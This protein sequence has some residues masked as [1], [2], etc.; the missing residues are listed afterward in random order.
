M[1]VPENPQS[2]QS[3]QH[4]SSSVEDP[5][6]KSAA[7]SPARAGTAEEKTIPLPETS[8]KD[9]TQKAAAGELT[10]LLLRWDVF[11][12]GLVMMLL[13][14][15][16]L[17]PVR[18]S[19][20][21][22][23]LATGR[24]LWQGAYQFGND[25]FIY[26]DAGHYTV[27]HSWLYDLLLYLG[28]SSFG[29]IALPALKVLLV[30]LLVAVLLQSIQRKNRL[31]LAALCPA[32]AALVFLS[33]FYD[34]REGFV[35]LL[36]LLTGFFIGRFAATSGEVTTANSLPLLQA[37]LFGLFLFVVTKPANWTGF[38]GRA[39]AIGAAVLA[40]ADAGWLYRDMGTSGLLLAGKILVLVVLVQIWL[41]QLLEENTLWWPAVAT[42]LATL[43]LLPFLALRPILV[44]YLFL[45]LTFWFLERGTQTLQEEETFSG[46]RSILVRV[47][48]AYWPILLVFVL[49]VNMDSWFLLGPLTVALYGAGQLLAGL[50]QKKGVQQALPVGIVLLLGLAIC[51]L[52]PQ[53]VRVFA[54]PV[55]LTLPY[56]SEGVQN[57]RVF[58]WMM[59][60][61]WQEAYLWSPTGPRLMALA[62]WLL[63]ALGGISFVV[64]VSQ[65]S[66]SRLLVWAAFLL[67]SLHQV[68]LLGFFV[69]V[70]APILSLN[71]IDYSRRRLGSADDLKGTARS[72][73][74]VV[75]P[76]AV[77]AAFVL[78]AVA[79][80]GLLRGRV[81][82]PPYLAMQSDP[83][84][85]EAAKQI[86]TWRKESKW[87]EHA[88]GL[89]ASPE[90]ANY[91]AWFNPQE[92][93]FVNAR[94]HVDAQTA[95]DFMTARRVL[96]GPLPSSGMIDDEFMEPLRQVMRKWKLDYVI[97]HAPTASFLST[98]YFRLSAWPNE[99]HL[100]F[101]QGRT[102]IFGWRDPEQK[103]SGQRF[104][105]LEI[106]MKK[107]AWISSQAVADMKQWRI[108]KWYAAI[109]NNTPP[110][111]PKRDEAVIYLLEFDRLGPV[112]FRSN[113][114]F[115]DYCEAAG[116]VG[117]L[118]T[119]GNWISTAVLTHEMYSFHQG[120]PEFL[121]ERDDGPTELLYLAIRASRQA[122][123]DDPGDAQ[124]YFVLG[125]A[126]S[127]LATNTS[128]RAWAR[129]FPKIG[130]LRTVQA[131]A[132]LKQAI[133]LQPDLIEA[134]LLLADLY[135]ER[136]L[137][138]LDLA[139][140]HQ[141]AAL[142]YEQERGPLPRESREQ[143]HNRIGRIKEETSRLATHVREQE[144]KYNE[145]AATLLVFPR[146]LHAGKLGL[147]GKAL[148]TLLA[149]DV[150][151]FG[152]EGMLMELQLLL[153]TG[154]VQEVDEWMEP[155]Q[156]QK[157][158]PEHYC[159]LQ[160]QLAAAIGDY[161]RAEDNVR[162]LITGKTKYAGMKQT[163][164]RFDDMISNWIHEIFMLRNMPPMQV[165]ALALREYELQEKGLKKFAAEMNKNDGDQ[166]QK[167]MIISTETLAKQQGPILANRYAPSTR[168]L[169]EQL[170]GWLSGLRQEADAN[171]LMGLLA[172]E[173][174]RTGKARQYLR[175]ALLVWRSEDR[176]IASAPLD[177]QGRRIAENYLNRI[178]AAQGK[179]SSP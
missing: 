92:K 115:F 105:N 65:L 169:K 106:E 176:T 33:L 100:L 70:S 163:L 99:W 78:L 131:I 149:S 54:L 27:N 16:A 142:K 87:P 113:T 77:L 128:E 30:V 15:V 79:W 31:W 155:G 157:L 9:A 122:I 89:N 37:V 47:L 38:R 5:N 1:G 6:A 120:L 35:S 4:V 84:I 172:L 39:I 66:W 129:F 17:A 49:W 159:W 153:A 136:Q 166:Q 146:A 50:Q 52:N 25:P 68:Y 12:L 174:G 93:A 165:A 141:Q 152:D 158:G 127:K 98:P 64:N 48:R 164:K 108:P 28:Y 167:L 119:Q 23:H 41:H 118:A 83:Y 88:K 26:T 133:R 53:H 85:I 71:F 61:P 179:K 145:K 168:Q 67:L 69:I 86:E 63:V 44:S 7:D 138:Y 75:R 62:Y 55:E 151:V 154:R 107:R 103:E 45:A 19:D 80:P 96:Y 117:Q 109:I 46:G 137:N 114:L 94:L 150:S 72:W 2:S 177:F 22:L 24:G 132:A 134:H 56:L 29:E 161:S 102:A 32:L 59:L 74:M 13:T 97:I 3:S 148:E 140:E 18:N 110:P 104:A 58:S 173:Q 130:R 123:H 90:T 51:V 36:D 126:Y 124:A 21:W 8:S 160:I 40:I 171:T 125:Q 82:G 156:F 14:L 95:K 73:V 116:Y 135:G 57:D 91:F 60:T 43:A 143:Y 42:M 11:L 175:D 20:V 76:L 101:F 147:A 112:F 162:K 111:S 139:L 34:L 178:E 10:Q 81:Q 170:V 121:F 144:K